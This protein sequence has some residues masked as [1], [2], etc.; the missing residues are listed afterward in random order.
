[1]RRGKVRAFFAASGLAVS[2]VAGSGFGSTASATTVGFQHACSTASRGHV[3]CL[4]QFG[5]ESAAASAGAV[6]NHR[7]GDLAAPSSTQRVA[8]PL[9][10]YWP[11]DIWSIYHLHPF[12]GQG[13][14]VAVVTAYDNPNVEHDLATYRSAFGLT[15]C[16]SRNGCFRKLNQRGATVPPSPDAAWGVETTLDVQAVSA[17]CPTCRILLVEADSTSDTDMAP[18]VNQAVKSGA[19]VVSNSYGGPEDASVADIGKKYYT[20][21]GVAMIASSGDEGYGPAQFPASWDH[22]VAVGGTSVTPTTH[23]WS[24]SAWL[25]SGSGCSVWIPKPSWQKDRGCAM[26]TTVDVSAL[27][28][29]LTGLA[30][31]DTYGMEQFGMQPGWLVAGGTSL[32]APLM[33]GMVGLAGN[34]ASL[35]TGRYLYDHRRGLQDVV[36]GS[37]ALYADCGGTYLCNAVKGYDGP[38]GLGTPFGTSSL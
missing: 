30:I 21:P 12:N 5:P 7:S 22:V 27:G 8:P 29:P 34:P 2:L 38:T 32:A 26:R 15:P 11:M 9:F 19:T 4:V 16:T 10:G 3:S 31:F 33:A 28:D 1:M 14:T 13:Q 37:N 36:V 6:P 35:S 17:A 18:A 23:G 25:G 20:H 24:T